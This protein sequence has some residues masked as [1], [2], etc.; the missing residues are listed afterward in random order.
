MSG[1]EIKQK[2]WDEESTVPPTYVVQKSTIGYSV[3][4]ENN[5]PDDWDD[6]DDYHGYKFDPEPGY[7]CEVSVK[8]VDVELNGT[9]TDMDEGEGSDYKQIDVTIM[10]TSKIQ[11]NITI[12]AIVANLF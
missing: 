2:Q 6:I 12:S 10:W 1:Q 5:N 4:G 8:Y 7:S 11:K 9:V 3:D